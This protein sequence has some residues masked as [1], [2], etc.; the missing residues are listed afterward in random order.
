MILSAFFFALASILIKR[1]KDI[2]FVSVNAWVSIL[3]LPQAVLISA[4]F[5]GQH[6]QAAMT[7]PWQ[8]WL[9]L[10]YMALGA[11]I[12]GQG[13]WYRTLARHDTNS[14][15]PFTLLVPVFGVFF[16]IIFLGENLDFQNVSGGLVTIAGVGIVLT[17]RSIKRA[18]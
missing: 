17:H 9:V 12:I 11:T 10:I 4:C 18:S 15:M 3:S 6:F 8:T 14:V 2:D 16:G 7:A 13:L 1:L 5:E